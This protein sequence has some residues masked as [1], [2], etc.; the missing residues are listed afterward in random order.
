MVI[1]IKAWQEGRGLACLGGKA[2]MR[3]YE[4]RLVQEGV[5][6]GGSKLCT[7]YL[8]VVLALPTVVQGGSV[9]P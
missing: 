9:Y 3:Q 4:Y 2:G 7:T 6:P 8:L 1:I 5:V